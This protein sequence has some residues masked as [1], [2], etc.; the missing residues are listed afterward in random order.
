MTSAR[1]TSITLGSS[2]SSAVDQPLLIT[3]AIVDSVAN[4]IISNNSSYGLIINQK[5]TGTNTLS[6]AL[7]N[8]TN[9]LIRVAGSG[10]VTINATISGSN[11]LAINASSPGSV[12]FLGSNTYTGNTTINAGTLALGS[13]GSIASSSVL[14]IASGATFDVKAKSGGFTLNNSMTIDVDAATA[15]KIDAT[16]VALTYGGNL[17]L[18]ITTSTPLSSYNLF[19]LGSETG[20]F[21]NIA[22][23]GLFSGSMTSSGG[24]W[25]ALNN[26]GYDLTFTES[27]GVLQATAAAVPEPGTWVLLGIAAAF[28]LYRLGREKSLGSRRD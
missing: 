13:S 18:N 24:V 21:S 28:V 8:A 25:T 15:G 20:T 26:N 6:I 3:G 27:T 2:S 23:A 14:R 10:N 7:G 16:G 11:P 4:V 22:L 5:T 12:V 19:T 9:N 17:T 1:T